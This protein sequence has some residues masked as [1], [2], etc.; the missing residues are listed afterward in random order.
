LQPLNYRN[1]DELP[2]FKG[3]NTTT[4]FLAK[5]LFDK[6]ASAARAGALG[7]DSRELQAIRVEIA[8]SHVAR[9]SYESALE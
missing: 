3:K 9:A 2:E 1:L 4:E 7:R 8:E 6:L 5:Y